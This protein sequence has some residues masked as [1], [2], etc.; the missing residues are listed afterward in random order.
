MKTARLMAFMAAL[1]LLLAACGGTGSEPVDGETDAVA[2]TQFGVN[3]HQIAGVLDIHDAPADI[4]LQ[5]GLRSGAHLIL[6]RIYIPLHGVG[7]S[8]D[9]EKFQIP[10]QRGLG[11]ILPFLLQSLLQFLLAVNLLMLQY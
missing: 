10:G 11:Y 5:V 1:S 8:R 9:S 7:Q 6:D 4:V 2:V 3:D